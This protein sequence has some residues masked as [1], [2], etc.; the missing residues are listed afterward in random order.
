MCYGVIYLTTEFV[1]VSDAETHIT[2][3]ISSISDLDSHRSKHSRKDVSNAFI[4]S[5]SF[6]IFLAILSYFLCFS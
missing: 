5:D 6:V 2:N 1:T 3:D 4:A